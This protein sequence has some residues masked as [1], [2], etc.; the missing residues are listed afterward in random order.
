MAQTAVQARVVILTALDV[1]YEAVRAHLTGLAEVSHPAGTLFEVG[2]L[3]DSDCRV[4]IGLTGAGNTN[5]AVVAERSIAT[6]RPR[7]LFFVGI[8]GALHGDLELGDV[9][10][11][12]KVYA[13]HGGRADDQGFH[14]APDAWY[15]PHDLQQIAHQFART[16]SWQARLP[17]GEARRLILRSIA[18]GEVVLN[19]AAHP[20]RDQIN[21][22]YA[23]AAAIEME[24]A[25]AARAGQLNGALP[26]LAIRGISDRADGRKYD[27]DGRGHQAHAMVGAAAL[28]AALADRVPAGPPAAEPAGPASVQHITAYGGLAAGVQHG[29]IYFYGAPPAAGPD[30]VGWKVLPRPAGV[31]WRTDRFA[32]PGASER[33]ALELHLVAVEETGRIPVRRLTEL[34]AELAAG[35]RRSGLFTAGQALTVAADDRAAWAFTGEYQHGP[36]G[37]AVARDGQRSAWRPLPSDALGAVLDEDDV[38]QRLTGMLESLTS[39]DL[40]ATGRYAPALGIEPAAM[41]AQGRVGDMPRRQASLG[42]SQPAS[43]RVP[44]EESVSAEDLRR[45]AHDVAAELTARLLAAFRRR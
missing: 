27:T 34:P 1:E 17:D 36:A 16:G 28:A 10:F 37:L 35:G 40:P 42:F 23:D 29:D 20:L 32:R 7:A 11:G 24:S 6:F 38:L 15:P 21:R 3:R 2:D 22:H 13:Y 26:T 8:A 33:S 12:E 14:A 18:A 4:A 30:G 44:A 31:V 5:A 19:S 39:L 41:V 45:H 25:G 9:I 43:V